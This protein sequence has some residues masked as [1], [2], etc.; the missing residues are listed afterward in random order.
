M[1]AAATM[2]H[3]SCC[4][5]RALVYHTNSI[6]T[7]ASDLVRLTMNSSLPSADV[8]MA[9]EGQQDRG[10]YAICSWLLIVFGTQ[11][12]TDMDYMQ[13][14]LLPVPVAGAAS[15]SCQA[16]SYASSFASASITSSMSYTRLSYP[17]ALL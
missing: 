12:T 6:A 16:G 2:A 11:V 1:K 9:V 14:L 15:W 4:E 3:Q 8:C 13:Q 7:L 5:S 17:T 10:M